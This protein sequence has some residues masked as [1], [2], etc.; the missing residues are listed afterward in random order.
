MSRLLLRQIRPPV[1]AQEDPEDLPA[2]DHHLECI[3]MLSY[4]DKGKA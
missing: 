1:A 2:V 3:I 4:E